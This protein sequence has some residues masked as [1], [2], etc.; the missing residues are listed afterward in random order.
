[1]ARL[2]DAQNLAELPAHLT[3]NLGDV[4]VLPASGARVQRGADVL[5][6]LGAYIPGLVHEDGR[7]LAP[8]GA[9]NTVLIRASQVG[10]ATILVM[11]GDPW[12]GPPTT[13]SLTVTVEN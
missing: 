13:I 2:V 5:E 9:P 8:M 7:V 1:V 3:L 12:H 4:L 10:S 11:T 6:V